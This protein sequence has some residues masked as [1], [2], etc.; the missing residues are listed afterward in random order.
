MSLAPAPPHDDTGGLGEGCTGA[1][2]EREKAGVNSGIARKWAR[3]TATERSRGGG[4]P[5]AASSR[6]PPQSGAGPEVAGDLGA[7][8]LVARQDQQTR[9][10]VGRGE[11]LGDAVPGATV[12]RGSFT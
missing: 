1:G 9:S 3:S 2:V 6:P 8:N 5:A 12:E 11:W 10:R 7:T 4:S